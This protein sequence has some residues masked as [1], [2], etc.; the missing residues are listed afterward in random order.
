MLL[1]NFI[2]RLVIHVSLKLRLQ[3]RTRNSRLL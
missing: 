2:E 3:E 1:L